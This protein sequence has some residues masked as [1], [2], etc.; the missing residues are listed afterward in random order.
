MRGLWF[1]LGPYIHALAANRVVGNVLYW[2]EKWKV[3]ED[4]LSGIFIGTHQVPPPIE[5]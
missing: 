5:G 3:A 1:L 2:S 4:G